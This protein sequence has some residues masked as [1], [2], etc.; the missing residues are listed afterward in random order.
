MKC[1][2]CNN[3]MTTQIVGTHLA[4][5][6][7]VKCTNGYWPNIKPPL[8]K[9]LPKARLYVANIVGILLAMYM[10]MGIQGVNYIC[11]ATHLKPL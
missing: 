8:P 10:D 4:R 7:I 11:W 3:S 2:D 1:P 6:F 5:R 9:H